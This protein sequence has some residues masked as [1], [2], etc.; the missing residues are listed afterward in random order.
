VNVWALALPLGGWTAGEHIAG[1]GDV[2]G[3]RVPD[4]LV[5]LAVSTDCARPESHL[6]SVLQGPMP[7][8]RVIEYFT[9]KPGAGW[10][11]TGSSASGET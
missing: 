4:A 10:S 2:A 6:V 8:I 1:D 5:L 11:G 9:M 3:V 7:P